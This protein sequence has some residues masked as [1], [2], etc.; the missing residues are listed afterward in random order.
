MINI[1]KLV[2]LLKKTDQLFYLHHDGTHYVGNK[3]CVY[4]LD[5]LAPK[6]KAKLVEIGF[7][8][9]A[10]EVQTYIPAGKNSTV[11]PGPKVD[12]FLSV[13]TRNQNK[14]CTAYQTTKLMFYTNGSPAIVCK[15]LFSAE[16]VTVL[17]TDYIAPVT[18][19]NKPWL[20]TTELVRYKD[21]PHSPV[22]IV[23]GDNDWGIIMPVVC[24][25][26]ENWLRVIREQLTGG[27][28]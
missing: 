23:D 6:L 18:V 21:D 7:D 3:Y 22:W 13:C 2:R 12:A 10:K 25:E 26:G 27:D 5:A 15:P 4:F 17:N 11:A 14:A 28:E 19:N 24:R 8:L 20:T 16:N 9:D 1:G